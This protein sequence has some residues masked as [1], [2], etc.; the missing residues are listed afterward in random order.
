MNQHQFL[1]LT[2]GLTQQETDRRT[3]QNRREQLRDLVLQTTK[4]DG[5]VTSGLRLWIKE[6]TLAFN[7]LGAAGLVDIVTKS[8]T[9][10]LRFEIER[11]LGNFVAA[12]GGPRNGVPWNAI[13]DHVQAQFLNVDEAAALREE[14]DKLRQS[15]YEPEAQYSRR[16]REVADA[17]YPDQRN[18]DQERILVRAYARGLG[19][20]ALARKLVEEAN[21]NDLEAA[22]QAVATFS[23]RKDAYTR[24][25]REREREREK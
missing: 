22:I 8:V 21:P 12:H 16:F 19:S 10:P 4:C 6:V 20:Q 2:A 17:A 15:P 3:T 11:F 9:G 5:P 25:G 24:L 13:R 14:V 18:A 7:L 1:Q 23:E